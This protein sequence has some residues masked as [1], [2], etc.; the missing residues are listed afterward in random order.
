MFASATESFAQRNLNRS[1]D[2]ALAMFDPVVA[3]ARQ[4]GMAVRGY[5]SMCF[6]DPWEVTSRSVRWSTWPA[7]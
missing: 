5:L 2:E 7:G 1:V 6:G 4:D 3:D